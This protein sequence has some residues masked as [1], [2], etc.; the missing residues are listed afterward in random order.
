MLKQMAIILLL[1]FLSPSLAHAYNWCNDANAQ[2]C[3]LFAEGSGT[4]I[5]DS[6]SNTNT[7]TFKGA[8]EPAWAAMAGTNAPSYADNM[9]TYDGVNDYIEVTDDASITF[10]TSDFS[11]VQWMRSVV[12]PADSFP[13][14]MGKG[15]TGAGEWMVR[16]I[17]GTTRFYGDVGDVNPTNSA[18]T[19]DDEWHHLAWTIDQGG[20]SANIWVDGVAGSA[21]STWTADFNDGTAL[22][23][24][25]ADADGN[26]FWDGQTAECALFD[27]L[28]DETDINDIMDNGLLQAPSGAPTILNNAVMNNVVI[29]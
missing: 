9:V 29:N 18:T 2:G 13:V 28:L 3:W 4:T 7:A 27:D 12:T 24:G 16:Q 19:N 11:G 6:S 23:F 10:G 26:R 5:A 25:N 21:D 14:T 20:T 1:I 15:D 17:T 22:R 8:G